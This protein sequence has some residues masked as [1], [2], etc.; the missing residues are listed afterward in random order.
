VVWEI[1]SSGIKFIG[2]LF[3]VIGQFLLNFVHSNRVYL[4]VFEVARHCE[5]FLFEVFLV[6]LDIEGIVDHLEF[7]FECRL[8]LLEV[9]DCQPPLGAFNGKGFA[10]SVEAVG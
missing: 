2:F 4:K 6:F 10:L 8:L 3:L 7:N 9:A 5:L 1:V